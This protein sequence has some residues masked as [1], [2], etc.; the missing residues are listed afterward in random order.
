MAVACCAAL[1][2]GAARGAVLFSDD[3]EGGTNGWV[4]S[5]Q[6]VS[7]ALLWHIVEH[8]TQTHAHAWWYGQDATG[9]YRDGT[10]AIDCTLTSPGIALSGVP[11]RLALVERYDT[12]SRIDDCHIQLSTNGGGAWFTASEHR[13]GDSCGWRRHVVDLSGYTGKTVNVRFRFLCPS[14]E[15][16]DFAGWQIGDILVAENT[17]GD[18]D[19]L[20][21]LEEGWRGCD[22]AKADSDGDGTPDGAEWCVEGTDPTNP[23]SRTAWNGSTRTTSGVV[24]MSWASSPGKVYSLQSGNLGSNTWTSV[25]VVTAEMMSASSV[26]VLA[27]GSNME[28]YRVSTTDRVAI[29]TSGFGCDGEGH[30]SIYS[31]AFVCWGDLHS[32][33][34]YSDDASNR[35][36]CLFIPAEALSNTVGLLDF[37]A[38]T[39]HA[40]TN[41]PGFYTLAKWTNTI[42]QEIAFQAS[43]TNMVVFPAFE[44]TKTGFS[45]PAL[46]WR[47]PDG[48]GHKNIILHDFDH[49]PPRAH[50]ADPGRAVDT[51][52]AYLDSTSSVGHYIVIPHHPAKGNEPAATNETEDP[53]ISMATDWSTNYLREDACALAEIYSRHGGSEIDGAEEPVHNFRA[54]AAVNSALDR[55]LVNHNPVYKIGIIASTDTHAGN[56]GDV[57]EDAGNVDEPR[58]RGDLEIADGWKRVRHIRRTNRVGVHGEAGRPGRADGRHAVSRRGPRGYQHG[59]GRYA[60]PRRGR[61]ADQRDCA[62]PALSQQR[63][64][65]G[66]HEQR[67]GTDR[68]R[69]LHRPASVRLRVL[70]RQSVAGRRDAERLVPMGA[71]VVF[72]HL[73]R[74]TVSA[75][76]SPSP[77][78][79]LTFD[80]SVGLP[81]DGTVRLPRRRRGNE[82]ARER[83]G[84]PAQFF[85]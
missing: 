56:P 22:P 25:Y 30:A 84:F 49:L 70:P 15:F 53:L 68:A 3:V 76:L 55:W 40:E 82:K 73:D 78:K 52:L 32:H 2:A 26:A 75:F 77:I 85:T 16:N 6:G 60:H 7:T 44:F 48:N 67:V 80:R 20:Y 31:N 19:G 41:I 63:L 51:L 11:A 58:A 64:R 24:E 27:G 12:E 46:N 62:H 79:S 65:D 50:G 4:C 18:G 33:T 83:L 47:I 61:F 1:I 35:Q 34:T 10:N 74:K 66:R 8:D 17:D 57:R 37:V 23:L 9:S 54:A 36:G 69:G 42:A 38:I 59:P 14:G 21:D 43:H 29:A 13:C 28:I 81:R 5:A 45:S 71:R 72:A 39:D